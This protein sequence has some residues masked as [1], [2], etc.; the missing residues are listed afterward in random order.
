MVLSPLDL[1]RTFGLAGGDIFHGA[2]SLDQLWAAR[3]V[4]GHGDYR[5][6]LKGLYMCGQELI[7]AAASLA[8]PA[9]M[10]RGDPGRSNLI[11]RMLGR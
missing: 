9:T 10:P 3:P 4:L 5:G 6:P 2:L 8:R 11:G 7:P 1:E